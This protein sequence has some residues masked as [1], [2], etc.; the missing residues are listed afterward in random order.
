MIRFVIRQHG[1]GKYHFE[2]VFQDEEVMLKSDEYSTK[3]HCE[4]AV[5]AVKRYCEDASRYD[6]RRVNGKYLFALKAKNG[7]VIGLS[8]YYSN[9]ALRDRGIAAVQTNAPLAVTDDL[10]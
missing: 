8:G 5:E 10:T 1:N 9:P 2:L 7:H 4:N 3:A 6:K